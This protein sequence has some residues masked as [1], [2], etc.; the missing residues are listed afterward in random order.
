ML[1]F[2]IFRFQTEDFTLDIFNLNMRYDKIPD[3]YIFILPQNVELTFHKCIIFGHPR[4][5]YSVFTKAVDFGKHSYFL[6]TLMPEST[7]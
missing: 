2:Y 1:G 7:E 5:Y 4:G 3:D 6:F